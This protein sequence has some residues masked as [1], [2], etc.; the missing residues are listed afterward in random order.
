MVSNGE[1]CSLS[2]VRD[3]SAEIKRPFHPTGKDV[4]SRQNLES[5]RRGPFIQPLDLAG[6]G[7]ILRL[8]DAMQLGT[9]A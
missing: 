3:F 2:H 8:L 9:S 5:P 1:T 6:R 7:R 4:C